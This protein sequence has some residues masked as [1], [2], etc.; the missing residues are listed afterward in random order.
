MNNKYMILIIAGLFL[1][2]SMGCATKSGTGAAVGAVGGGLIGGAAGHWIIGAGLGAA[3]GYVIGNQWDKYD[4]RKAEESFRSGQRTSWTN[5]DTGRSYTSEPSQSYMR[6]GRE[7]KNVTIT[8]SKG[9][10]KQAVLMK[11]PSGAWEV[12]K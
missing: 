8:D 11:T 6:D 10:S 12:V 5:P 2:F 1:T 4:E 3:L 7:Y 9:E